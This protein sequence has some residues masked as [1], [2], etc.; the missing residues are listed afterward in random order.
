MLSKQIFIPKVIKHLRIICFLIVV[1]KFRVEDSASSQTMSDL[2][3]MFS[4]NEQSSGL[5]GF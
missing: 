2:I 1:M 3:F 4:G 5:G